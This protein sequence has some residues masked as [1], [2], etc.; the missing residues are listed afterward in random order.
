MT[1]TTILILNGVLAAGLL[2]ALALVMAKAHR[3]AGSGSARVA[4]WARPL[5][6]EV[7]QAKPAASKLD[8]AA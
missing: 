3:V 4:R 6:L 2:A 1:T 8:R 5:E 7:V